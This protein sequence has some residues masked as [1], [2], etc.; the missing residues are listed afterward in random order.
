[1]YLTL[2]GEKTLRH[3]WQESPGS[4]LYLAGRLQKKRR[5][6]VERQLLAEAEIEEE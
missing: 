2:T 5:Q 4:I 3:F 6:D 1:M